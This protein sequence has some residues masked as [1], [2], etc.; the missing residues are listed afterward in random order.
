[1]AGS[2]TSAARA[3][4]A[5]SR[6]PASASCPASTRAPAPSPSPSLQHTQADRRVSQSVS[7][8]VRS[9]RVQ[10]PRTSSPLAAP[11][12]LL[13]VDRDEVLLEYQHQPLQSCKHKHASQRA[14]VARWCGAVRCV[15]AR[16]SARTSAEASGARRAASAMPT[17]WL[18]ALPCS[19]RAPP[20]A[21]KAP[22]AKAH[23]AR[24]CVHRALHYLHSLTP[25]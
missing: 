16:I 15:P 12:P 17:C 20:A 19:E 21:T 24:T 22:S 13:D 14:R 4:G 10:P 11:L 3:G 6:A 7:Q 8:S 9:R 25:Q 5:S 2:G 18:S 1:M 23:A